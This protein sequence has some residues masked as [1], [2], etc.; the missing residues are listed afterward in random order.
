MFQVEF[1]KTKAF[2]IYKQIAEALREQILSGQLAPGTR[3]PSEADWAAQL[4]INHI[5][6]RKS[7]ALLAEQ[8]LIWQR[9][10]KGS[11]VASQNPVKMRVGVVI[12]NYARLGNDLY[13]MRMLGALMQQQSQRINSETV[14]LEMREKTPT[15]MMRQINSSRV[16]GLI[17][18]SIHHELVEH[19]CRKIFNGIPMVFL[20]VQNPLIRENNR[21]EVRLDDNAI[22]LGLNYLRAHGC[23][24]IAY[25]SMESSTNTVLQCR[26]REFL[27]YRGIEK[28]NLIA[29]ESA[30]VPGWYDTAHTGL[31]ELLL[32]SD[33]I[34]DAVICPGWTFSSGAWHGILEAG[35]K[36]PD[37]IRF[38][39]F[40]VD[41]S[42][43]PHMSSLEQPYSAIAEKALE[44]LADFGTEG[45]H[46]KQKEYH[47]PAEVVERG[48]VR[49]AEI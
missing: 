21:Y 30:P 32:H 18:L 22:T 20:N 40:D 47:F 19:L 27:E 6:L 9:Q 12:N 2:P 13:S 38:L 1:C 8:K 15:Q 35:K 5:T 36:V 42:C 14:L 25:V 10:G 29:P 44:L 3:L 28:I 23:R 26:N 16:T 33:N 7:L 17:I 31:R 41:D 37:E 4:G 39:G 46:M 34:P 48:S 24:K 11:F 49:A 45:K 43:N